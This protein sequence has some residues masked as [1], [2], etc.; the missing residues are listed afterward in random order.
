M[1]LYLI[2]M[3][4]MS[5]VRVYGSYFDIV[6]KYKDLGFGYPNGQINMSLVKFIPLRE[7]V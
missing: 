6:R 5:D 2:V 1:Y 3:R 7:S 4:I